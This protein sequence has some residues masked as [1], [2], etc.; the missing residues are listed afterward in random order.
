MKPRQ[1]EDVAKRERS[2]LPLASNAVLAKL[3][4]GD[5]GLMVL[6]RYAMLVV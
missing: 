4:N 2:R 5:E 6:E 1:Y 3:P